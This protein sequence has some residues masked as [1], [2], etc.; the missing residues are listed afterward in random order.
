MG[1]YKTGN[2]KLP[3]GIDFLL[4]PVFPYSG[5]IALGNSHI[6][7][8]NTAGKNIQNVGIFHNQ[9]GFLFL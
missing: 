8:I 4:S 1:I 6:A 7:G 9:I 3:L 5:D 2:Q